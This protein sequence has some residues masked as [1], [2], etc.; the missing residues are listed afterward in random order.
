MFRYVFKVYL[1]GAGEM[2]QVVIEAWQPEF[3]AWDLVFVRVFMAVIKT[4]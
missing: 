2:V 1:L 3:Y 4:Q